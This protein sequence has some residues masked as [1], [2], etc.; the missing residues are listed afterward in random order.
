MTRLTVKQLAERHG[1]S[2]AIIYVWV[3]ER[4]FSVLRIGAK[5][6]RGRILIDDEEFK[7]CM[8][9]VRA[10]VDKVPDSPRILVIDNNTTF[11]YKETKHIY[12]EGV[13]GQ[14]RVL[15]VPSVNMYALLYFGKS[16]LLLNGQILTQGKVF[17]LTPGSSLRSSKVKP[18]YYSDILSSFMS[19]TSRAKVSWD[20][21]LR[22]ARH[23]FPEFDLELLL[24]D[25]DTRCKAWILSG[26]VLADLRTKIDEV[27]NSDLAV[28]FPS[29]NRDLLLGGFCAS[30]VRR[31]TR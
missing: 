22:T 15:W 4:R 31:A 10:G 24:N 17:I 21:W 11:P 7:S 13:A 19:D 30:I 9:F 18:V 26:S 28:K 8:G 3:E 12:A 29:L 1:V 25:I 16:E 27:L 2:R 14:A 6:R 5:G 23:T 20:V